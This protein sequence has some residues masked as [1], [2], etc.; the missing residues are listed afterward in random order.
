M[1]ARLFSD[2][3]HVMPK[4]DWEGADQN[5]NVHALLRLKNTTRYE[6]VKSMTARPVTDTYFELKMLCFFY[7][8][9]ESEKKNRH[10]I[11][12]AVVLFPLLYSFFFYFNS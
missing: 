8:V 2:I 4:I 11:E 7:F 6:R 5:S 9:L 10:N 1:R 3:G 12:T